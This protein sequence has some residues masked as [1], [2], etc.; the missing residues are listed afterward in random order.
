MKLMMVRIKIMILIRHKTYSNKT[1]ASNSFYY[2]TEITGITLSDN[3]TLD[4]KGIVP[5]K[6]LS[7][8]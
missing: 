4:R 6:Y 8:F 3:D 1:V 5:L 7:N 2:K